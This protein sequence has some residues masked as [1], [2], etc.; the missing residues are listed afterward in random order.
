MK[1]G[2][3]ASLVEAKNTNNYVLEE[4]DEESESR[5]TQDEELLS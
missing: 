2:M 3:A 4:Q 1:K 5:G